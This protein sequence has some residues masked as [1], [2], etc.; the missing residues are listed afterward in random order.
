MKIKNRITVKPSIFFKI[1]DNSFPLCTSVTI[2]FRYRQPTKIYSR[3]SIKQYIPSYIK[4]FLLNSFIY[5][6]K[7]TFIYLTFSKN[8]IF[9]LSF[10]TMLTHRYPQTSLPA[11]RMNLSFLY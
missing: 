11:C 6:I 8:F 2:H 9:P 10:I 1:Y 7:Q 5:Y 3:Y 4:R